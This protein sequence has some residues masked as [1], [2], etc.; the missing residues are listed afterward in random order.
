M[1]MVL[2]LNSTLTQNDNCKSSFRWLES[3]CFCELQ[4]S[5]SSL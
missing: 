4:P 1:G 2:P 3:S 5:I